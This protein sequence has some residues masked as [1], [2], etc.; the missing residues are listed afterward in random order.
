MIDSGWNWLAVS[1]LSDF[2]YLKLGI[3]D[4]KGK[5]LNV[6]YFLN[7]EHLQQYATEKYGWENILNATYGEDIIS[8]E[9][10]NTSMKIS[11]QNE[12]LSFSKK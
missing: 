7:E 4:V 9:F 5:V 12:E 2:H 11:L 10:H 1:G 6:D 3:S 8:T